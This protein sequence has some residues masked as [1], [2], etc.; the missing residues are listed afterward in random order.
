MGEADGAK[1]AAQAGFVKAFYALPRFRLGEP[2]QPW[3]LKIVVNEARNA[4]R[5]AGRRARHEL[6]LAEGRPSADVAPSPEA[7]AFAAERRELLVRTL[8]GLREEDRLVITY[9]YFLDLSEGEMAS[10][11]SCA[12]GT[13]KSRLS[14]A[15][16]RLR[17]SLGAGGRD[18]LD[19]ELIHD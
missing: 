10:V 13:V 9:R 16:G 18:L 7:A 12:P 17:E 4:L 19:T 2:F 5:S 15:L 14:R 11:M 8:N 3:L 1:D 6:R